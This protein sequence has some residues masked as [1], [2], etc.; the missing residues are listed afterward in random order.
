MNR[1][2]V[3]LSRRKFISSLG[4]TMTACALPLPLLAKGALPHG[5]ML[6]GARPQ[7]AVLMEAKKGQ[8]ELLGKGLGKTDIW[9]YGGS[10]PG[11]VLRVKQG[12]ELKV[13]FKNSLDQGSTIH[14]HGIRI[15][16]KMDG[17]AGLTQEPVAP[18]ESFD[19]QFTVPDAG[20]YWY[21]PHNRTWEQMARGL[22]G[23]LIVEEAEPLK[24]DHDLALAFDDWQLKSDGQLEEESFGRIGER[25][26]GGRIGNM[27][28]VNGN[29]DMQVD[30]KS[31]DRVRVRICNTANARILELRVEG[32]GVHVVALDGQ[33]V[34]PREP[35]ALDLIISPSQ[36]V[37][38]VLDMDGAPGGKAVISEVSEMRLPLVSFDLHASEKSRSK[39][40]PPFAKLADNPLQAPDRVKP[41][42]VQLDMTGGAM[43]GMSS[44]IYK[45]KELSVR[46][47]VREAGMIWAFNGVAGMPEKPLFSAKKGQSV[48]L[49]MINN[50]SFS[51][52][53]HLHGHHMSEVSRVRQTRKG[54]KTIASRPDWRDTVLVNRGEAVKVA[55][56]ADNPGKWMLHCHMLEHQAGGMSTWFEVA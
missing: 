14:W 52:A 38:L 56:V 2:R 15:D 53:M 25:A 48:E 7:D 3:N 49:E 12:S 39:P 21:H 42:E 9:G 50:T 26:H 19:Y 43:G 36:R 35:E 40:L 32:C 18:G 41:L 44:A 22:Y 54:L 29:S 23:L 27:M 20:T 13:R 28:T 31:G 1:S 51:H 6:L 47:L 37:D 24:V 55:F 4:L 30:V 34:E 10:V 45:G 11:P 5:A 16:N 33:P 46:E 17:V 8:V